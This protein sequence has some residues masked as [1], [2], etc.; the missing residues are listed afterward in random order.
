[1]L[2]QESEVPAQPNPMYQRSDLS[3]KVHSA[4]SHGTNRLLR[5]KEITHGNEVS[6]N[7]RQKIRQGRLVKGE[8][9]VE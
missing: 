8:L 4:V 2:V 9:G 3:T 1:M 7:H 6:E 5:H